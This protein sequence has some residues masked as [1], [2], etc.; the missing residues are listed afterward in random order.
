MKKFLDILVEKREAPLYHGT[1][2]SKI[3]FIL[4]KNM[5]RSSHVGPNQT[6]EKA[7]SLTRNYDFADKWGKEGGTVGCV[8]QLDQSKLTHNYKL[9]PYNH[10]GSGI[11]HSMDTKRSRFHDFEDR[12]IN[13]GANEYEEQVIGDINNL[14]RYLVKI[15]L[16]NE[17]SKE[18][19]KMYLKDKYSEFEPL[20]VVK[21]D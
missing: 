9:K 3:P 12:S 18:A 5:L 11:F 7:V 13:G 16:P 6:G 20:F 15:F 21:G 2:L 19:L 17:Q 4:L 1:T 8:L 10:W 14:S